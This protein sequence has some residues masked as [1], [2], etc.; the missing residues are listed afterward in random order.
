MLKDR[1]KDIGVKVDTEE[2]KIE[3]TKNEMKSENK[4]KTKEDAPKVL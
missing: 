2:S 1:L 4:K 3:E